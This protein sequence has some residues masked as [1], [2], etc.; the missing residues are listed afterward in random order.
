MKKNTVLAGLLM[1]SVC[2]IST[3]REVQAQQPLMLERRTGPQRVPQVG[4]PEFA[5]DPSKVPKILPPLAP[6][7]EQERKLSATAKVFVKKIDLSGNTVFPDEEL[8]NI[9]GPYENRT[10]TIGELHELRH[11]LS[12][13]Y[14]ENGYVNSG[15][16]VP[17][18]EVVDGVIHLQAIEGELTSIELGGNK[19]LKPA[20]VNKRIMIGA[21]TPLN[22]RSLQQSLTL[23]Q[24]DPLIKKI[25]AQLE[26]G[27][28]PGESALR[29]KV[30]ES[31]PYEGAIGVNNE[32]SPA[33]GE[34]QAY[35]FVTHRNLTGRGDALSAQLSATEGLNDLV[36][37]Y[38]IPLNARGTSAQLFY[39]KTDSDVIE[40]PFD[41]LDIENKTESIE[42][43]VAHPFIKT[44]STFL[45]GSLGIEKVHSETSLLGEPFS[46][47]PGVQDGVS[48]VSVVPLGLDWTGRSQNSV[49]TLGSIFRFG[50]DAFGATINDNAPDSEFITWQGLLQYARRLEVLDSQIAVRAFTQ[51]ADQPLLP[52]EKLAVG[53]ATTVRGYRENQFVRDNGV[54]ASLEWRIPVFPDKKTEGRFRLQLVPFVDYGRSWN[55]EG[56]V[57]T[58]KVEEIS[59]AGLGFLWDPSP[60]WHIQLFL[61]HAFDDINIPGEKTLQDEGVHF[62]V[63]YRVF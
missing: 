45:V 5:P 60:S 61:A 56:T 25:N 46:F 35:V 43:S 34:V 63:S 21:G 38:A 50:V 42:L 12:L 32:R 29:V 47:S 17:D 11:K 28:Q 22:I 59:S 51:L 13:H 24:Q 55:E 19:R 1:G 2:M 49:L 8:A 18:Q 36:L 57:L 53:G 27:F 6:P 16:I 26:P 7:S 52:V 10:I 54:V 58:S 31:V 62:R 15:V 20:Y 30:E 14:F 37:S 4:E 23:L 40:E 33:V 39:E 9:I 48:D 41:L 3:V 44:P